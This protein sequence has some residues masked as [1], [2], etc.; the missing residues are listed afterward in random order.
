MLQPF[1]Y[2]IFVTFPCPQHLFRIYDIQTLKPYD[3]PWSMIWIWQ[4]RL[5]G[6]IQLIQ[7]HCK[8]YFSSFCIAFLSSFPSQ[9]T[10]LAIVAPSCPPT[11]SVTAAGNSTLRKRWT[12]RWCMTCSSASGSTSRA[13]LTTLH[14][15]G[16]RLLAL[17]SH[18]RHRQHNRHV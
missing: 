17:Y 13:Q 4:F 5:L 11:L 8:T 12:Q 7:N 1:L 15:H 18:H 16:R 14:W 6:I 2:R 3:G 9:S 10:S